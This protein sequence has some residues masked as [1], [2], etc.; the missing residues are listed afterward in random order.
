[1]SLASTPGRIVTVVG[2][3]GAGKTT[4]MAAI[5]GLLP[6]HGRIVIDGVDQRGIAVEERVAN[7]M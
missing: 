7:G 3:N 1:M 4:L 5:M 2:P 6:S